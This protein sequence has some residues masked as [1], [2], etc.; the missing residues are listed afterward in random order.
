MEN[1]QNFWYGL[2]LCLKM[3]HLSGVKLGIRFIFGVIIQFF[4]CLDEGFMWGMKIP[5]KLRKKSLFC[6]KCRKAS[7]NTQEAMSVEVRLLVRLSKF[8]QF[9]NW[10][11]WI[12]DEREH[13]WLQ[14]QERYLPNSNSISFSSQVKSIQK[15]FTVV[16]VNFLWN[17]NLLI[18]LT[19][20][21]S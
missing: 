6:P 17:Y 7:Y 9:F 4:V 11:W 1:F 2:C 13:S 3:V 14:Y 18:F 19:T 21:T 5:I 15:I 16:T 12:S 20:L 10:M 8:I